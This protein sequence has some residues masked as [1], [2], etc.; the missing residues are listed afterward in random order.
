MA[1]R[2]VRLQFDFNCSFVFMI[3]V[4]SDVNS[5]KLFLYVSAYFRLL[6]GGGGGGGGGG[7]VLRLIKM[8]GDS[9]TGGY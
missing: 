3:S 2:L 8:L 5:F 9:N 6:I 4:Y 1:Q 7:G